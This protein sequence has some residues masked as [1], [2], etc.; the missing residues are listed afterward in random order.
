M[1]FIQYEMRIKVRIGY[2]RCL[3]VVIHAD[4][5][6][7]GMETSPC[8]WHRDTPEGGE[9]GNTL[10]LLCFY[11]PGLWETLR[12][13]VCL[14]VCVCVCVHDVTACVCVCRQNPC[15]P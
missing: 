5:L 6:S 15:L 2:I 13:C 10:T 1:L 7:V 9:A 11:L 3:R 8:V 14:C 4:V 12:M